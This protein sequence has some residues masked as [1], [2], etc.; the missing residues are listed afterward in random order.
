MSKKGKV[1]TISVCTQA[2]QGGKKFTTRVWGLEIFGLDPK[3][4]AKEFSQLCAAT[5]VVRPQQNVK[6]N[7]NHKP[8]EV[9]IQGNVLD[10]VSRVLLEKYNVPKKYLETQLIGAKKGKKK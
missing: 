6:A 9:F 2:I 8:V 1:K 5:A 7:A 4:I 3:Q 10:V